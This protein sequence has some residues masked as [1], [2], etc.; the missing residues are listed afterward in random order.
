MFSGTD[1]PAK[2]LS[3]KW[4]YDPVGCEL[5]EQICELPE[6]YPTRTERALL[7]EHSSELAE[8]TRASSL[9]ELG[10]GTSDRP[11][12]SSTPGRRGSL[13]RFVAFDVAEPTLRSALAEL[14]GRYPNVA[15]AGVVGDF[16]V[17]LDR[18]PGLEGRLLAFLGGTIGNLEPLARAEFWPPC[19]RC[20]NPGSS[21]WS[22]PIW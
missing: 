11:G 18:I 15:M 7:R 17:H 14:G 10:S 5:F 22:A 12:S 20:S 4:L 19:P 21:S 9:V 6:Y 16:E 2:Q 8:L 13:K 3:P 1:L